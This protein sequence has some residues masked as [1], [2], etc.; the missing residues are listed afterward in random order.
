M[1]RIPATIGALRSACHHS[2]LAINRSPATK[3]GYV[4]A[5]TVK[6]PSTVSH[7]RAYS[8]TATI[9]S[10][11]SSSSTSD[12]VKIYTGSMSGKFWRV[13]IFSASTSVLGICAQPV[14]IEKGAAIA[15]TAGV[16]A[17]CSVA[18]FFAF[19]TPVLLHLVV[20]KYVI[21]MDYNRTTDEYTATTISLL[22]RK[23]KVSYR[24]K[25]TTHRKIMF[26]WYFQ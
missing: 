8:S 2:T 7:N 24:R 12:A 16:V 17:L 18:G 6:L 21:E 14:L 19:V 10:S 5:A 4:A 11:S 1:F 15:G 9:S 26:E 13:K 3:I 25:I 23:K 20:K 22:M